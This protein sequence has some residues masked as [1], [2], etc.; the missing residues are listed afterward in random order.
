MKRSDR[1][2]VVFAESLTESVIGNLVAKLEVVHGS[3]P[4]LAFSVRLR[5]QDSLPTHP[6]LR[7]ADW[8]LSPV[9]KGEESG[10]SSSSTLGQLPQVLV[11]AKLCD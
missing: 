9:H 1:Q 5:L 7:P 6:D 11:P 4:T 8:L 3:A 10:S 2:S